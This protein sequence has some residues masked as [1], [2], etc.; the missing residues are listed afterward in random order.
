MAHTDLN[1][2]KE[3]LR[4][5]KNTPRAKRTYRKKKHLSETK[6]L[7]MIVKLRESADFIEEAILE[8]DALT[9]QMYKDGLTYLE[10][11]EALKINES[12]IAKR[13]MRLKA[14]LTK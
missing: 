7:E 14:K 9:W 11:A 8:R 2:L 3:R 12:A 6:K 13:I 1:A 10:L 4:N 5:S